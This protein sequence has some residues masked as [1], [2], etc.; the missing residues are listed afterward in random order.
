MAAARNQERQEAAHAH[1]ATV[2]PD[3]SRVYVADLGMDKVMIYRL[4]DGKLEAND[5][6]HTSVQDGGGPRHFDFHP[7]GRN[8]YIINELDLTVTACAYDADSG[9]LT[10]L[11]TISTLPDG[12]ADRGGYSCADIHVSPDG[13]FVYGSNRGHDTLAIFA[14]D[15][16]SGPPDRSRTC[17]DAGTDAAQLQAGPER[18]LAA[19]RQSGLRR[20]R[21]L[22]TRRG[23]RPVDAGRR[24]GL[25]TDAGLSAVRPPAVT[26]GAA[27]A[28]RHLL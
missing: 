7:N 6:D 23:Q 25:G 19:G 16:D 9:A 26:G 24:D 2:S 11:Q 1:S 3:G 28:V 21:R 8:A 15:A 14:V 5:P 13:R 27:L 12:V 20:H 22:P 4:V 17:L 10:P 18:R